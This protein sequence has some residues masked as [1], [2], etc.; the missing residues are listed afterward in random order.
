MT[1]N[2]NSFPK[3]TGNGVWGDPRNASADKGH[4]LLDEIVRNLVQTI[5]EI[6]SY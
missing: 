5:H 3:I 6:E 2:P 1:N 4:Q